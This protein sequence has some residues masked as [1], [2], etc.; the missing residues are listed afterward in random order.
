MIAPNLERDD[1]RWN[2]HLLTVIPAKA[3]IS[4]SLSSETIIDASQNGFPP[5]RE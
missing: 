1:V 5:S 4:Y 3:G 2:H